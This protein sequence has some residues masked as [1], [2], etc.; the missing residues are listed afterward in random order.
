L[1][2]W[3]KIV[4]ANGDQKTARVAIFI[5]DK[6]DF[7]IKAVKR[8][9]ER[10]YI[11]IKGSIQEEDIK[12]INIYYTYKY[13]LYCAPNT[14]AL[15]YVS[16]KLTSMKGEINCN[17]R[18][19]GNFNTP[20]TSMHRSTKQK[21]SKEIQTLNDMMDQLYLFDIYRTF[22]LKTMNFTIFSSAHGYSLG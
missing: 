17:T 12:S 22:H 1:E 2:S 18:R 21:T 4:H 16:Q 20:L 3:K 10:H 15:Q 7:E 13:I 8:A 19:V 5:S 14:G 9:K 11:V 6:I